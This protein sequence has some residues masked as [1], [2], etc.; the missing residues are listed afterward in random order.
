LIL[1]KALNFDSYIVIFQ[2][3]TATCFKEGIMLFIIFA[4]PNKLFVLKDYI[5]FSATN[6][7]DYS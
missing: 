1:V 3:N 6:Y 5:A 2:D 4:I 7:K